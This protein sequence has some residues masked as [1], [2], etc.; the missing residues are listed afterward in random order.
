MAKQ[1]DPRRNPGA[2]SGG[3]TGHGGL[4]RA[5]GGWRKSSYSGEGSSCLSVLPAD[6]GIAIRDSKNPEQRA[7]HI[8][9]RSWLAFI[10][11]A[12]EEG[13]RPTDA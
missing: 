4:A 3:P 10:A 11:S 6:G 1:D 5:W 2:P 9:F 13:R 8:P 12:R 7:L